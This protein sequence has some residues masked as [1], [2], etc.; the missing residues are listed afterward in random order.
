MED[1]ASGRT[2][3]GLN[4]GGTGG[5]TS[6]R[7]QASPTFQ[8]PAEGTT[9]CVGGSHN[10]DRAPRAAP[11]SVT[12]FRVHALFKRRWRPRAERRT[13][14]AAS[15]R[16][17]LS[18]GSRYC[19]NIALGQ[20][21]DVLLTDRNPATSDGISVGRR[22]RRSAGCP[23]TARGRKCAGAPLPVLVIV[24][25]T[26]RRGPRDGGRADGTE[27]MRD[28]DTDRD[29]LRRLLPGLGVGS[30]GWR[31]QTCRM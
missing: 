17:A 30:S 15:V 8:Q 9:Q 26:A 28:S 31:G 1:I 12:N 6:R 14:P 25:F 21:L 16:S 22:V 3:Q 27:N 18:H 20:R 19:P 5:V 29:R 23:L 24:V 13:T 4:V 7:G 2:D 11:A 10:R